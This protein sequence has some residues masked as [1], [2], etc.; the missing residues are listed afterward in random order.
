MYAIIQINKS[1]KNIRNMTEVFTKEEAIAKVD[2]LKCAYDYT[3][4]F[5]FEYSELF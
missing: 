3:G 5:D 4:Q 1:T 2:Y